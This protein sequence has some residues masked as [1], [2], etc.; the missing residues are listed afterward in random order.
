MRLA[1]Q[2][3]IERSGFIALSELLP[4]NGLG[5][6]PIPQVEVRAQ[7]N[8]NPPAKCSRSACCGA[9]RKGRALTARAI[10]AREGLLPA[11]PKTAPLIFNQRASL[12]SQKLRANVA[13]V[14]DS[15]PT[16]DPADPFSGDFRRSRS[17]SAPL[18]CP[19][20]GKRRLPIRDRLIA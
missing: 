9:R 10:H 17:R 11:D 20:K 8:P 14:A 6:G 3:P 16:A 1:A 19:S 15:G 2:F 12:S 5:L 18:P 13:S 7:A 4:I